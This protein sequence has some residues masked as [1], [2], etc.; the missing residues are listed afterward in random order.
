[1]PTNGKQMRVS[2]L[3]LGLMGSA[4]AEALLDAGHLVTV[5][6]R[7]ATKAAPL[8]KKGARPTASAAEAL[9]T[10]ETSIVCVLD[11]TASM[12]VLD[13]V[14]AA[15]AGSDK[16]LVQLTT[17]TAANSRETADWAANHGLTY[18]EGSILGVPRNVREGSATI[19][20]AGQRGVFEAVAPLLAPFGGGKLIGEDI[21]A[22]VTFD[23][24]FYAY[25]Y[26]G[27][28]AFIQGA[29]LA[30]AKGFSIEAFT[31]IVMARREAVTA[32]LGE[33]GAN[34]AARDHHLRECRADVWAEGLAGTL[35]LCR[36]TGVDDSLPAAIMRLF[37]RNTAAGRG[38][39]ELSSVF[40]TL[41]DG[42]HK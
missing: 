36:E 15:H 4:L 21:G 18:I 20:A 28:F 25:I 10:S 26:G 14:P 42:A 24:V 11:H 40:E 19:V 7:T 33:V 32:G 22:A 2:V 17:M 5:W 13:G 12:E 8:T 16:C 35:G 9:A 27:L 39:L 3:G 34:I 29:A 1:M 23:R 6:N 37:Q 30:H 38:S 41:I 31:D